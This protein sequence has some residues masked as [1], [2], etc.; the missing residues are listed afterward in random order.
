MER[1]A[2]ALRS[3]A[4]PL[5]S[6]RFSRPYEQKR[7]KEVG[8]DTG[9]LEV[10][11]ALGDPVTGY[12]VPQPKEI[13]PIG[14]CQDPD[15]NGRAWR[16]DQR[17]GVSVRRRGHEHRARLGGG[18]AMGGRAKL[19]LDARRLAR[20]KA[21]LKELPSKRYDRKLPEALRGK[22]YERRMQ[23]RAAVCVALANVDGEASF[24]L[25]LRSG[26]VGT[27]AGQVSFP[28]GHI[29]DGE[30]AQRAS[31]RELKEETALDAT[32]L[33]GWHE[34]RAVTGTMVSPIVSFISQDLTSQDVARC[35]DVSQEVEQAFS[36]RLQDLFNAE[37]RTMEDLSSRWR[38]PRF[39]V[40]SKDNLTNHPPIWGLT[41]F[42]IDGVLRDVC[43]PA[44]DISSY[45]P[46]DAMANL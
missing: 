33:G 1:A 46:F 21:V 3:P 20:I 25:T 32:P 19:L 27:H 37:N 14:T 16:G 4:P 43:A 42:I 24:L 9:G 12:P 17:E 29:E 6:L 8:G 5:F 35:S 30:T 23:R 40:E 26:Q 13:R 11:D 28:G 41:A 38:M 7:W 39:Q 31:L 10:G 36:V 18:T 22:D 45:P 44:F 34:V 2:L 15:K